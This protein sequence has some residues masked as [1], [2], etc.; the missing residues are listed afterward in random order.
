MRDIIYLSVPVDAKAA[1][2]TGKG[3][4]Y[5]PNYKT[6]EYCTESPYPLEMVQLK[7]NHPNL[8]G[9]KFGWFTVIG[10]A[11]K[12]NQMSRG[13]WVVRC[14]CGT[15]AYRQSKSIR[16][17]DNSHDCCRDCR[18]LNYLKKRHIYEQSEAR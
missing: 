7:K 11:K 2:V 8:I 18:H 12:T 6:N 1:I 3:V 4:H 9:A 14:V 10:L 17:P 16:N 5:E 13:K 15:Y